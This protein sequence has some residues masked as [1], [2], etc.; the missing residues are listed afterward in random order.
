MSTFL[1][2]L[3]EL[4]DPLLEC[5]KTHS[6]DDVALPVEYDDRVIVGVR[7]LHTVGDGTTSDGVAGEKLGRPLDVIEHQRVPMSG[8][9]PSEMLFL[10]AV[11]DVALK[12]DVII[13]PG[14]IK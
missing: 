2:D 9:G 7:D 6:S 12:F 10:R 11:K 5:S 14:D 4:T 3:G 13:R 8:P 1:S